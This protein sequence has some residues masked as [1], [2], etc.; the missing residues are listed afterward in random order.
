MLE[1]W[2]IYLSQRPG[3]LS[4][5]L[6][7]ASIV[8]GIVGVISARG[9][10]ELVRAPYIALYGVFTLA[11]SAFTVLFLLTA[12]AALNGYLWAFVAANLAARL[13]GGFF[14]GR[15]SAA[16]ALDAH[17]KKWA[18]LL[19]AFPIAFIWLMAW[20]SK[21]GLHEHRIPTIPALSGF[22]GIV[23]GLVMTFGGM[24][25]D[26]SISRSS[27]TVWADQGFIARMRVIYH[28]GRLGLPDALKLIVADTKTPM[29]IDDY[30]SLYRME[31]EG[32]E[33]RRIYLMQWIR[34]EL[35]GETRKKYISDVCADPFTGEMLKQGA[36][37]RDSITTGDG[38][39]VEDIKITAG[40]CP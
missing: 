6:V 11:M 18:G 38:A 8:A 39:V 5:I 19:G 13:V 23:L 30:F 21:G 20:P 28:V 16:R 12:E 37:I 33:L 36:T 40:D 27:A 29:A 25:F 15:I 22:T 35:T 34:L 31:A 3:A 4:T 26:Q 17:G 10:G 24:A 7:L 9:K 1:V 2:A 32:N 14:I